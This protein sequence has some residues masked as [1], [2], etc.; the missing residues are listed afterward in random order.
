MMSI[1]GARACH[2]FRLYLAETPGQRS[3]GLMYVRDMAPDDG[4]LFI[5]ER[6]AQI[7]MWMRNTVI[8]LDML[9]VDADGQILNIERSTTPHSRRS[10]PSAGPA[11]YV[12]EVNAGVT[13]ELGMR[14]GTRLFRPDLAP[15]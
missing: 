6:P 11:R 14:A 12:V 8:P 3:R 5:Y 10:I 9:F 13:A 15:L 2:R 7:S 4:M 1:D